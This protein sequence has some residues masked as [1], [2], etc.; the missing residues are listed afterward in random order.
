MSMKWCEQCHLRPAKEKHK[1]CSRKCYHASRKIGKKTVTLR[2][3]VCSKKFDVEWR[4]RKTR[5]WCS[6]QCTYIGR[7]Q[8]KRPTLVQ[9]LDMLDRAPVEEVANLYS[10][11][12]KTIRN[13]VNRLGGVIL[14]WSERKKKRAAR[15]M[16]DHLHRKSEARR[17]YHKVEEA[18]YD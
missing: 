4:F 6:E 18:D 11:S 14:P 9:L 16:E 8:V 2:C 5:I 15:E 3:P 1:Y 7:R 12:P 13:W 10:V 17:A